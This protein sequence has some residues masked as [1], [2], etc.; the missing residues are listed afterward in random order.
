MTSDQTP[1]G[2]ALGSESDDDLT[3]SAHDPADH[4]ADSPANVGGTGRSHGGTATGGAAGA[5]EAAGHAVE[6][7]AMSPDRR[8][9]RPAN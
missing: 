8:Q 4:L 5:K 1:E 3:G 9:R 2:A 7:A 6:K